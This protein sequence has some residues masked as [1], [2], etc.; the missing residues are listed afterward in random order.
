M[1]IFMD[2]LKSSEMEDMENCINDCVWALS[3][4][5]S[6]SRFV[7]LTLIKEGAIPILL[8]IG[9]TSDSAF[10]LLPCVRLF[11]NISSKLESEVDYLLQSGVLQLL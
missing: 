7:C 9:S 5:S 10:M 1:P 3:K 4:I 6:K 8:K 2:L 11:G